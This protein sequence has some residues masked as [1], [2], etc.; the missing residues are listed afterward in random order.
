LF[1][2]ADSEPIPPAEED[3]QQICA[4]AV[5]YYLGPRY[6]PGGRFVVGAVQAVPG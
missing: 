5:G 4:R 2:V 6:D 1:E 3:P